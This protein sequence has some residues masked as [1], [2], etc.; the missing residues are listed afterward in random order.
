MKQART[1]SEQFAF[2]FDAAPQPRDTLTAWREERRRE[3]ENVC[4]RLGMPIGQAVE[5]RLAQG[6]CLR[7][8]LRLPQETLWIEAER[9]TAILVIDTVEFRLSEVESVIRCDD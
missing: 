6:R 9:E 7:G 3:M 1:I 5:V 4:R 8:V 2:D